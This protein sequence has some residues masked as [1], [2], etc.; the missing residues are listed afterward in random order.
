ME[1]ESSACA[2]TLQN[3]ANLKTLKSCG[4]PRNRTSPW[5]RLR[6]GRTSRGF[7]RRGQTN[8]G[9]FQMERTSLGFRRREQTPHHNRRCYT[10]AARAFPSRWVYEYRERVFHNHWAPVC[11]SLRCWEQE[12]EEQAAPS[13]AKRVWHV[14]RCCRGFRPVARC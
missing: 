12:S 4:L 7:H 13:P 9:Y 10:S 11:S 2:L 14:A 5:T 8:C 1:G 3:C 6:K